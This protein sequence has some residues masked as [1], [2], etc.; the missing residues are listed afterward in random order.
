MHR[1][2][3]PIPGRVALAERSC[4]RSGHAT[5]GSMTP[6]RII[7]VR[8]KPG[9]RGPR[10]VEPAPEGS[11]IN[12]DVSVPEP[13]AEGRANAAVCAAVATHLHLAPTR[14]TILSGHRAPIKRLRI[15]D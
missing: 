7:V 14:V 15:D 11:G 12:F 8:V 3:W 4:A 13:P 5:V 2:S 10:R 1:K 6:V 9:R